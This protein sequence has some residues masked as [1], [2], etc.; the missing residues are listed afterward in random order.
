M[1]NL[2]ILYHNILVM[3]YDGHPYSI[4]HASFICVVKN[5]Y[6]DHVSMEIPFGS[7]IRNAIFSKISLKTVSMYGSKVLIFVIRSIAMLFHLSIEL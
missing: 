5:V 6:L 1:L 2:I 4:V 3:L 7:C